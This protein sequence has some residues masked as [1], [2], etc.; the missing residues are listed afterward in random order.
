MNHRYLSLILAA[1]CLTPSCASAQSIPDKAVKTAASDMPKLFA[2]TWE[3]DRGSQVHFIE[4]AGRLSG[5]Y[6]THVG[7]PD[8]SQ[9]FPLTGFSQ[10]DVITFTVNFHP[11]GSMTSWSGQLTENENGP[12][13]KTLWHLTRDVP[14]AKEDADLWKSITAGASEFRRP[15]S[16]Q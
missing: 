13:I 4:N 9:K 16:T 1:T 6:Q 2:G 15:A 11:F 7:Q 10:G 14:D 8:T 12:Y 5:H 3:N